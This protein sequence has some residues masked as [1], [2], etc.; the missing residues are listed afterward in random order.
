M[1]PEFRISINKLNIIIKDVSRDVDDFDA[2][3]KTFPGK[4]KIEDTMEA[5]EDLFQ[6]EGI[7]EDGNA[8]LVFSSRIILANTI[9]DNIGA[10]TSILSLFAF[11]LNATALLL[12]VNVQIMAVDD[13]K[14][15]TSVLRALGGTVMT[16]FTV[17]LIE[18]TIIGVIGA[19]IGFGLGYLI[20]IW[21]IALLSDVFGTTLS[22]SLIELGLL[23]TA[24]IIGVLLSVITAV[25]P[26]L[27]AAR[28]NI[29]NA[30]RGIEDDKPP[31]KGYITIIVGIGLTVMGIG[32]A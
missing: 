14:K 8:P 16:I 2:E 24:L 28:S 18:A 26:S 31:R 1:V 17:F 12:I 22:G 29:S 25:L 32:I 30:L 5:L 13:R 3:G 20:S 23:I 4:S 6:A 9:L 10:L 21:M 11:I 19:L 7:D 27:N 15:Q